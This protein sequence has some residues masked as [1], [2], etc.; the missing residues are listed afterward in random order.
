MKVNFSKRAF[1]LVLC[2][3]I[4]C[5][6]ALPLAANAQTASEQAAGAA[7]VATK[8]AISPA[9]MSEVRQRMDLARQIVT[10]LAP[11]ARQMGLGEGWKQSTMDI[12]LANS[13]SKL[14]QIARIGG[15]QATI[16]AATTGKG[17]VTTKESGQTLGQTTQDLTYKPFTPCRF[18]D[19]R[20]VGGK[21][22]GTR[23]YDLANTGASYGGSAGC[24]PTTL[25]GVGDNS[26]GALA[27]NI[28]IVDTS[29]GAPGF[30]NVVPT[31][32]VSTTALVNWSVAGI[33]TQDS[34][35]AVVTMDQC[36]S[37]NEFDVVTS[38]PVHVIIDL[39][40]AF[41]APQATL[42]N[43]QL[44]PPTNFAVNTDNPELQCGRHRLAPRGS[45]KSRRTATP[46]VTSINLQQSG[47]YVNPS[48]HGLLWKVR[49]SF[50]RDR[51]RECR[52]LPDSGAL[53]VRRDALAVKFTAAVS[54][55]GQVNGD[56]PRLLLSVAQ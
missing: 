30:V 43:C 47:S 12:L 6:T 48:Q 53:I 51:D 46:A 1:G 13:S 56:R 21:I 54:K 39:F 19:T 9:Q 34:N 15:Y 7:K 8:P 18:I 11:Q 40:G 3:G 36:G 55:W 27:M 14:A 25:A 42:L 50:E 37:L 41:I 23:G 44:S 2:T 26:F 22:S 32:A 5:V 4:S 28:A 45:R 16:D 24:T 10:N 35:Q 17:L 20:N 38:G 31:G 49:W 29:S 33:T 52:V